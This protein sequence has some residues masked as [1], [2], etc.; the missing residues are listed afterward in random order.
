MSHRLCPPGS[1]RGTRRKKWA[2][3]LCHDSS[4][5][6]EAATAKGQIRNSFTFSFYSRW[7]R[8][9]RKGPCARGPASQQSTQSCPRNSANVCVAKHRSFP[10]RRMECRPLPFSTSLS[11]SKVYLKIIHFSPVIVLVSVDKRS[12]LSS[13]DFFSTNFCT[14]L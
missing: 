13:R 14:I 6:R 8:S 11:F 4:I 3:D 1:G 7:H 10:T 2:G 5:R 12:V 9:S